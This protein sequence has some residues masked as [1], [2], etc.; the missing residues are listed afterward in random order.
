SRLANG[1]RPAGG[2]Q[3]RLVLI[4]REHH[5]AAGTGRCQD[6]DRPI[7]EGEVVAEAVLIRNS[8]RGERTYELEAVTVESSDDLAR[9]VA[10]VAG[11]AELDPAVA[12]LAH[13]LEH[14]IRRDQVVTADC[15]LP[16]APCAR[17]AREAGF[18]GRGVHDPP[19]RC[20][21]GGAGSR[22]QGGREASGVLTITALR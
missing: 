11:R 20:L 5:G 4:G 9:I 10:E 6:V 7:E 8:Q 14:S 15:P 16:D 17:R 19:L 22:T 18:Q 12:K 3:P 1:I 21:S 2:G 13:G